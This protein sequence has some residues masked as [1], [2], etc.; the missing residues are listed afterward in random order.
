MGKTPFD[1]MPP[2]EARRISAEFA[3]FKKDRKSFSGLEN[4]NLHKNGRIVVLETS[5]VPVPDGDGK[6]LGYREILLRLDFPLDKA[7]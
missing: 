6:L 7:L 3:G 5:G 1:L 4:L 2:E